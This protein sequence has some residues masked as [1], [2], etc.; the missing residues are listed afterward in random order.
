MQPNGY[1]R[2]TMNGKKVSLHRYIWLLHT[3][4]W[5]KQ[6][7]DHINRDPLD[8]RVENLRDVSRSQNNKNQAPLCRL[9]R[10]RTKRSG[11]PI[12]VKHDRRCRSRP[13][14]ARARSNGRLKHLGRFATPEEASRAYQEAVRSLKGTNA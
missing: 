12:G 1:I 11:L 6:E 14:E 3:G 8:N 4:D 5:P 7:I 9:G 13:Y 2:T 10:E